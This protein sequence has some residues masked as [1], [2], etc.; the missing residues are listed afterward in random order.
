MVSPEIA[1]VVELVVAD[2]VGVVDVVADDGTGVG[3]HDQNV[4]IAVEHADD[5]VVGLVAGR[6]DSADIVDIAANG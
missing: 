6:G 1:S 5:V 3:G 2:G 4:H